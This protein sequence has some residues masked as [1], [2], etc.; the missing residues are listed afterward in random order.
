[1]INNLLN[2]LVNAKQIKRE[3]KLNSSKIDFLING[4]CYLEVKTPLR[5]IPFGTKKAPAKFNSFER[6]ARHFT[7]ISNEI[8]FR[9]KAIV[10][11]CYLY[12]AEPFK[13][14]EKPNPE[15]ECKNKI[16][17]SEIDKIINFLKN[18]EMVIN[19]NKLISRYQKGL[20]FD[21]ARKIYE[22]SGFEPLLETI[23]YFK[24]L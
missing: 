10:L 20:T 5:F 11:L 14:P 17:L 23:V 9:Q 3:V 4:S 16:K 24:K 21:T 13:V 22:K 7:D 18:K 8:K 1:M 6:M 19:M 2:G 15:R 12:N